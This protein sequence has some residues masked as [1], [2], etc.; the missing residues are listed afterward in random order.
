MAETRARDTADVVADVPVLAS[1]LSNRNLLYNGAMQV[2]QRGTNASSLTGAPARYA[3]A[4]RWRTSSLTGV[5][6]QSVE[7]DAPSGSGFTKSLKMLCTT[8]NTPLTGTDT[9]AISQFLEGQDLQRICKG[10]GSAKQLTVSFWVKSNVT[11]T[12]IIELYDADNS[13]SVSQSYTISSVATWENKIITFPADTTGAFDNDIA[14]S[15]SIGWWL[16]AGPDF[17]SGTL[18]TTWQSLTNANRVV[19]QTNLAAATSN[20]WQVTGVQ[21]EVGPTATGFEFKSYGQELAE[22]QRYFEKSYAPTV[23]PGTA[24]RAGAVGIGTYF[25]GATSYNNSVGFRFKVTKRDTPGMT[26]YDPDAGTSGKGL[27]DAPGTPATQGNISFNSISSEGVASVTVAC[28]GR[29]AGQPT[30]LIFHYTAS[31]EL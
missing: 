17:Q 2:A 18:A 28:T 27:Y 7:T 31:A 30:S 23:A 13:R 26:G 21:L 8:P 25:N 14:G 1:G 24:G 20:Y 22:C 5:W 11:G 19:G 4:D 29:T 6:T 9:V 16:A 10:T 3:T 12:Y 15:L